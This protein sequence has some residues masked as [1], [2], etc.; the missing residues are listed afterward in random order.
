MLAATARDNYPPL[1]NI[2]LHFTIAM[3][4]NPEMA[5]RA[6]SALLGVGSVYLL[7]RVGALLWDRT[8]G[9]IAALLL[10]LSGFHVWYSTEA[11]MYT[12]LSFTATL[13]V[14]TVSW[15]LGIQQDHARWMRRSRSGPPLQPYLRKFYLCHCY[16]LRVRC[17]LVSCV[18]DQSGLAWLDYQPGHGSR[19][20]SALGRAPIWP[21]KGGFERLLAP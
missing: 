11:R 7:Y 2:I 6:P 3:F 10:A 13:F 14:L 12:L 17:S 18:L 21:R 4:G 8:T 9:L 5:L 15:Q 1:H 19:S 20:L 16:P